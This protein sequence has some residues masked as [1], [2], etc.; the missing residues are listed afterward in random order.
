MSDL[1]VI[2]GDPGKAILSWVIQAFAGRLQSVWNG[3]TSLQW[4]Q[5]HGL[6]SRSQHAHSDC[7]GSDAT[8]NIATIEQREKKVM[9]AMVPTPFL[10]SFLIDV[11]FVTMQY[12]L[13]HL[14]FLPLSSIIHFQL[15]SQRR[16]PIQ[17]QTSI[18]ATRV[19]AAGII[20]AQRLKSGIHEQCKSRLKKRNQHVA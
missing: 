15:A 10:A 5:I 20:G 16:C 11:C 12:E 4:F 2:G 13:S 3:A 18:K 17:W 6:R 8:W 7:T 1:A 19:L 9:S 14:K